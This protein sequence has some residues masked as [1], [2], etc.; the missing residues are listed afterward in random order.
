MRNIIYSITYD[1]VTRRFIPVVNGKENH[2][3]GCIT[4]HRAI[5]EARKQALAIVGK[6]KEEG[7][8]ARAL[9]KQHNP[10]AVYS[11]EGK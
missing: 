5:N 11:R 9:T 10:N 4:G 2:K 7:V 3:G 1:A 6:L 8:T